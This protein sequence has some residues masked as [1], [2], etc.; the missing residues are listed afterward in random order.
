MFRIALCQMQPSLL[1]SV[2]K[3]KEEARERAERMVKDAAAGGAVLV[4]L[5][6]MWTCPYDTAVFREYAEEEGGDTW[7][8]LAELAKEQRIILVGGSVPELDPADDKVYNT[9]YVFDQ[10]GACIAKHR[11]A[12]L[13]DINAVG[14]AFRESDAL[15]AGDKATVCEVTVEGS[16]GPETFGL[17]VAICYDI[18]FPEL[19]RTMELDGAKLVILPAAFNMTTGPAHWDLSHRMR[20]VDN[21]IYMAGCSPARETKA[22]YV[23]WGHS[24][25]AD[26]WGTFV[27]HADTKPCVLFAEI[28]LA[29]LEDV[30]ARLPFLEQ[31]RP[32]LY[33]L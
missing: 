30:R 7:R 18:R 4:S 12:H 8:F 15:G 11:K 27:A 17:G 23:A 28:D 9:A 33:H 10:T 6:E 32:E 16:E 3:H 1:K 29:H 2:R 22:S 25:V 21:Q 14:M 13:F 24:C 31:R 19:F 20:A 26:P 5:P